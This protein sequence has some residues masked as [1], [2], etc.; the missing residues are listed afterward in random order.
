ML[1]AYN[2]ALTKDAQLQLIKN[3]KTNIKKKKKK[4][5]FKKR[6]TNHTKSFNKSVEKRL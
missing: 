3:L 1:N 4:Q 5:L 6:Q 2:M